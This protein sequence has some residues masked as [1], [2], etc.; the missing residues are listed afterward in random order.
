MPRCVALL[1]AVNVGGRNKV[2]MGQLRALF[3]ELGH[4]DVTTYIQ[5]GNVVFTASRKV[6]E[7]DLEAAMAE[8]F[9]F[10]VD[11]MVRTAAEMRAVVGRHPFPEVDVATVHVGFLASAPAAKVVAGLDV[12]RFA[13]EEVTFSG[14]EMY[15]HLPNGMGRAK[16]PTYLDRRL[17]V[18]WTARNW[19]TVLKL[20]ELADGG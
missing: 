14:R 17:A 2:P 11:V 9:G 10:H 19:K 6:T 18:A 7:A 5:S 3:E 16:L 15:L 12:A 13:P 1:R 20:L 8:H 4:T